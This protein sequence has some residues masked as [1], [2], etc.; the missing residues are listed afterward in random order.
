[1]FLVRNRGINRL[2]QCQMRLSKYQN[3][4]SNHL[5][6]T[7]MK[8]Q[9]HTR[10]F[11]VNPRVYA[12]IVEEPTCMRDCEL[13]TH[14]HEE[15]CIKSRQTN[16]LRQTSHQSDPTRHTCPQTRHR[17]KRERAIQIHWMPRKQPPKGQLL[18]TP[19]RSCQFCY[20]ENYLW[21]GVPQQTA[22]LQKSIL[23]NMQ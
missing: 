6:S 2:R 16:R 7:K 11:V 18:G 21:L 19:Q 20:G 13:K 12:E 5:T 17:N 4:P 1:M 22:W 15:R 9:G 23:S 10:L 3:S 14:I 8:N